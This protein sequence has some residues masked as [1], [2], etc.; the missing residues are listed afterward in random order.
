MAIPFEQLKTKDLVDAQVAS[1]NLSGQWS[2]IQGMRSTLLAELSAQIQQMWMMEQDFL[3]I[4]GV[5]SFD[6]FFQY[7]DEFD[8]FFNTFSGDS[9]GEWILNDYISAIK[10]ITIEPDSFNRKE[11]QILKEMIIEI[12]QDTE[13]IAGKN[14]RE[15]FEEDLKENK[16]WYRGLEDNNA[17]FM[18]YIT[19]QLGFDLVI[20]VLGKENVS[21]TQIGKA[22]GSF[23]SKGLKANIDDS[24][25]IVV[26]NIADAFVNG[27][28][29]TKS[30]EI[31]KTA[32]KEKIK[33][34]INI[35]KSKKEDSIVATLEELLKKFDSVFS[36]KTGANKTKSGFGWYADYTIWEGKLAPKASEIVNEFKNANDPKVKQ[37]IIAKLDKANQAI[38]SKMSSQIGSNISAGANFSKITSGLNEIKENFISTILEIVSTT[39]NEKGEIDIKNMTT[40]FVGKNTNQIIGLLGE[41]RYAYF[42][43]LFPNFGKTYTVPWVAQ[44]LENGK[45]LHKDLAIESMFRAAGSNTSYGIQVKNMKSEPGSDRIDMGGLTLESA[46]DKLSG[47]VGIP[48]NITDN[49]QAIYEIQAFNIEYQPKGNKAEAGSNSE[50]KPTRTEIENQLK[51]CNLIM[52]V[53][54]SSFLYMRVDQ[55]LGENSNILYLVGRTAIFGHT[56]L[57]NSWGF[58]NAELLKSKF[59]TTMSSS[60]NVGAETIKDRTLSEEQRGWTIVDWINNNKTGRNTNEANQIRLTSSYSFSG[61]N[62]S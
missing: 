13:K 54:T 2:Q 27:A 48:S 34:Y 61:L 31:I 62:W 53:L 26:E 12:L 11:K 8:Q 23:T 59:D 21:K 44:E 25:E 30:Q 3:N 46:I 39:T 57:A 16:Q 41:L 43:K 60:L 32:L 29:N 9:I 58:M 18:S 4:L 35:N 55:S 28:I 45:Q 49:I 52:N 40:L 47:N 1:H 50:F 6:E 33:V 17:K 5:G 37:A 22:K 14:L 19:R 36:I 10:D 24:I 56:L 38:I 51:L 20:N 15:M 7:F 42:L